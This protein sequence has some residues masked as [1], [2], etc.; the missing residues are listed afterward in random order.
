M[1]WAHHFCEAIMAALCSMI[2]LQSVLSQTLA[3]HFLYASLAAQRRFIRDP[4]I[5]V[6]VAERRRVL[7]FGVLNTQRR[8]TLT[9]DP[10]RTTCSAAMM[11]PFLVH[12]CTQLEQ[13]IQKMLP[14]RFF[15]AVVHTVVYKLNYTSESSRARQYFTLLLKLNYLTIFPVFTAIAAFPEDFNVVFISSGVQRRAVAVLLSR[16]VHVSTAPGSH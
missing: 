1:D 4:N 5:T 16:V 6:S 11:N 9:L 13:M 12:F 15:G 3:L 7:R 2:F 8:G 10:E 14:T